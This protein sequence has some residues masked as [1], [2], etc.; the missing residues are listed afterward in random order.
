MKEFIN[1]IKEFWF[2]ILIFFFLINWTIFYIYTDIRAKWNLAHI[3]NCP[4][5]EQVKGE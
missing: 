1:F 5:V 3:K 2:V 4:C